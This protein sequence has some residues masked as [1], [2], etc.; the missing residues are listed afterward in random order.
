MPANKMLLVRLGTDLYAVPIAVIEEILPD[1]PIE[2]VPKCPAFVLGVVFVRGHLIPV[3]DAGER[4]GLPTRQ[5]AEDANIVCLRIGSR[6]MG[7]AFDEAIDLMDVDEGEV[8]PSSVIGA[9]G[10]GFTGVVEKHGRLIRLLDP[11]KLTST[12]EQEALAV[13]QVLS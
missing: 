1:L 6:L 9:Q 11:E 4:L 12:Q 5:R 8:L 3:L 7:V 2:A 10:G 13:D